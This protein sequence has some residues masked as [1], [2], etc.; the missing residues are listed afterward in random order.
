MFML[1]CLGKQANRHLSKLHFLVL[2][3]V[4]GVSNRSVFYVPLT[5]SVPKS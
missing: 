1:L 4:P 5:I 3:I 2:L